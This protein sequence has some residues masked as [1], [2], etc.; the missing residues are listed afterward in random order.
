MMDKIIFI[1]VFFSTKTYF[2]VNSILLNFQDAIL[3]II[4]V[5][6]ILKYKNKNKKEDILV[7]Y[8]VPAYLVILFISHHKIAWY[9][10]KLEWKII[11]YWLVKR[12]MRTLHWDIY[13]GRTCLPTFIY[14]TTMQ[15]VQHIEIYITQTSI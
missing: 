14:K 11:W 8:I 15:N 7:V 3:S 2:N 13:R 1:T 6:W 10:W 5:S 9:P 4:K 12:G